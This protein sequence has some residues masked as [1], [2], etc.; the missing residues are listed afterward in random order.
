MGG[1]LSNLHETDTSNGWTVDTISMGYD[2]DDEIATG[3]FIVNCTIVK[4]FAKI[5]RDSSI[6]V[7]YQAT[8]GAMKVDGSTPT[9]WGN[10]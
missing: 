4:D 6:F 10:D 1:S 7:N 2:A 8:A 3:S 9:D 5:G